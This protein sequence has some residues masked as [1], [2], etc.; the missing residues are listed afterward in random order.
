MTDNTQKI[1]D[2]YFELFDLMMTYNHKIWK[3]TS[4]PLPVNDCIVLYFSQRQRTDD[5]YENGAVPIHLQTADE[6]SSSTDW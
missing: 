2:I 3:N 6:A 4:N 1:S 5:D